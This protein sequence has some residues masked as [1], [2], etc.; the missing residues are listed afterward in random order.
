M[1][2]GAS[3]PHP[4]LS[5]SRRQILEAVAMLPRQFLSREHHPPSGL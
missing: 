1:S 4:Q 5:D 2:C 3:A